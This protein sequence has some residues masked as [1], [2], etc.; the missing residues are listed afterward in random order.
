MQR[1]VGNA[2]V[3][4]LIQDHPGLSPE[5]LVGRHELAGAA[6]RMPPTQHSGRGSPQVQRC[7]GAPCNCSTASPAVDAMELDESGE[8]LVQR[9]Y[10]PSLDQTDCTVGERQG[11]ATRRAESDPGDRGGQ[12]LTVT[13]GDT[14]ASMVRPTSPAH[15]LHNILRTVQ[16]HE[17]VVTTIQRQDASP[18][19]DLTN[20]SISSDYAKGMSDSALSDGVAQLRSALGAAPGDQGLSDNLT[21]LL[22]EQADRA[23][24]KLA[25]AAFIEPLEPILAQFSE[26]AEALRGLGKEPPEDPAV[27]ALPGNQLVAVDD[28]GQVQLLDPGVVFGVDDD[29]LSVLNGISDATNGGS[30]PA[31]ALNEGVQA[32]LWPDGRALMTPPISA[33]MASLILAGAPGEFDSPTQV[34]PAQFPWPAA[35]QAAVGGALKSG[36]YQLGTFPISTWKGVSLPPGTRIRFADPAF[37]GRGPWW[38]LPEDTRLIS[39]F[40]PTKANKKYYA[41]DAHFPAG[42]TPHDF[43]HVNQQGMSKGLFG[44]SDHSPIPAGELGAAKG[45]RYVRIGGR[46]LLVVGVAIDAYQMGVSINESIERGTPAP[47]VAQAVRT[48]GGWAGAWAGAKLA[49]VGGAAATVETGPG[50]LLGCIAGGAIGGFAGYFAA[51]WIADL[52]SEN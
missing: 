3:T 50:A 43:Y 9:Q 1:S 14:V 18:S 39:I 11:E 31:A 27:A 4:A 45:L 52:I 22:D 17:P 20:M 2:A 10:G 35:Q 42:S 30:L 49:C 37:R 41:W 32:L 12:V 29:L 46:V 7:G 38:S 25:Q 36:I 19:G 40:D 44:Q 34:G 15:P 28:S 8:T 23:L 26:A 16:R 51:D 21:V 24:T 5:S 13:S 6:R 48:I 47:A 33:D